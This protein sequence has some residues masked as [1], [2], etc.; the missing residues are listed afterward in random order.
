MI[1]NKHP[2][3]TARCTARPL[4]SRL[5]TA[6]ERERGRRRKSTRSV[7]VRLKPLDEHKTDGR[8]GPASNILRSKHVEQSYA[9]VSCRQ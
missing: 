6:E 9:I 8:T 3:R 1:F 4:D 5:E 7:R 2:D